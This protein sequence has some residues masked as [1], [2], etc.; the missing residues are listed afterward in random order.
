MESSLRRVYFSSV[1]ILLIK[2]TYLIVSIKTLWWYKIWRHIH[3][4]LY[5]ISYIILLNIKSW[6]ALTIQAILSS[7]LLLVQ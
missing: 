2:F 5:I 7:S 4:L 6:I 1:F 3:S